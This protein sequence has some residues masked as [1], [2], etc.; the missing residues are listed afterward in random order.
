MRFVRRVL[1]GSCGAL[2]AALFLGCGKD[3]GPTPPDGSGPFPESQSIQL[4]FE[5]LERA[6]EE[7]NSQEYARLFDSKQFWFQFACPDIE[8][9]GPLPE[10]WRWNEEHAAI[11]R[12]F[13]DARVAA[14]ECDVSDRYE[15]EPVTEYDGGGFPDIDEVVK[16]RVRRGF[17]EVRVVNEQG[18]PDSIFAAADPQVFFLTAEPWDRPPEQTQV[19]RIVAWRDGAIPSPGGSADTW[20]EVKH[21]FS[22]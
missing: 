21:H 22:K 15:P 13:A 18:T 19:W 3:D 4:L 7:K 10:E 2:V 6:Y 20:G 5:N 12:M 17:I 14:I 1:L 8:W 16:V 11:E 9:C